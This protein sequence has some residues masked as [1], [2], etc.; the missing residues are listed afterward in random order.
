MAEAKR[1]PEEANLRKLR[2]YARRAQAILALRADPRRW[3]ERNLFIRTKDQRLIPLA[4]NAV[5]VDYYARRGLRDLIL[6]ARQ[7][8]FTTLV[9]VVSESGTKAKLHF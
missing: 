6:K 8:G 4:L 7:L 5:Q 3:I 1:R 2:E 9:Y